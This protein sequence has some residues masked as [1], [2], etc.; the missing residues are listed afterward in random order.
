MRVALVL[1]RGD[2]KG[3]KSQPALLTGSHQCKPAECACAGHLWQ[4][5][6]ERLSVRP[7][8][9]CGLDDCSII[10]SLPV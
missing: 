8:V 7:S 5:W 3:P 1:V 4:L 6:D 2:C 9:L 10:R